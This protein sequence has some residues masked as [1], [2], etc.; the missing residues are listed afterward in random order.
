MGFC[1]PP[2]LHALWVMAVVYWEGKVLV[3]MLSLHL[4]SSIFLNLHPFIILWRCRK[5]TGSCWKKKMTDSI[6][7]V[8]FRIIWRLLHA[9]PE[10]F[11]W[12]ATIC[13]FSKFSF[14]WRCSASFSFNQRGK[15][16]YIP[17]Y[18][19]H[20][21]S[22]HKVFLVVVIWFSC[23]EILINCVIKFPV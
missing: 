21:P 12:V 6:L 7:I 1:F 9:K 20:C 4:I 2:I 18:Y 14:Q 15:H 22:N 16:D 11:H 3:S 5:K 13:I 23:V 10:H 17:H 8:L 19:L